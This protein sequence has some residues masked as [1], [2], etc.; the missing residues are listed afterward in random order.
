MGAVPTAAPTQDG[1]ALRLGVCAVASATAGP[2]ALPGGRNSK[3]WGTVFSLCSATLGAGALSLPYAFSHVG[4][5]G[6]VVLLVT[7]AAASYFSIIVLTSAIA[8]S[9]ARSYEE[10]TVRLFGKGIGVLVELNIVSVCFGTMIA[11]TV[12]L[13]DLLHPLTSA[14]LER[15]TVMLLGWA[16]L[17]LPLSM[18]ERI[19]E[20]RCA[21]VFGVC[22]VIYLVLSVVAHSGACSVE[23]G[24]ISAAYEGASLWTMSLRSFESMAIMMFAFTCQVNVPALYAELEGK[25][26][27]R[28][29]V[30][31]GR[32]MAICL[33]SYVLVGLAGYR[34]APHSQP[35]LLANYCVRK[36]SAHNASHLMLP[37]YVAIGLAVCIAYPFNVHPCR[38]TL[39]VMLCEQFGARTRPA[40]RHL[41][42]TLSITFLAL[43][44]AIYV[45]G[46][47]VVFQ[48]MGSTCSAFVCFVLP[49]AFGLKLQLPETKGLSGKVACWALILGGA[50]V[51]AVATV[52]TFHGLLVE[53]SH[54]HGGGSGGSSS[55]S[56][57]SAPN[58]C[59]APDACVA[60]Y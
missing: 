47:N 43:L 51:G 57:L 10:L 38:Y 13:G 55:S 34:D 8:H 58:V 35:N 28:M 41:L 30:V 6:G 52:I 22:S 42:W 48:L 24:S 56:L 49:G 50:G 15:R 33:V 1:H 3:L 29:R 14:W 27:R 9:G 59:D 45:P 44:V 40:V 53:Q 17:M 25:S 54:L 19:S 23:L 4:A 39:D 46:I 21:S 11:Y 36:P 20:L 12:A 32:A 16:C 7:T 2:S 60:K 18:L 26:L 31:A 37:A 5:V